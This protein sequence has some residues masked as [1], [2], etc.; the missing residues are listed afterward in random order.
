MVAAPAEG[1]S[2]GVPGVSCPVRS[3]VHTYAASWDSERIDP[4]VTS[5]NIIKL[6]VAK[7]VQPLGLAVCSSQMERPV[8]DHPISLLRRSCTD[9]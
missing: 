7:P 9:A 6:V 4:T 1:I 2:V 3:T 8:P 5:S